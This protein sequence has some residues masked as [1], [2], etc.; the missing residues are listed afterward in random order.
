MSFHGCFVGF[1]VISK[2]GHDKG[3]HYVLTKVVDDKFVLVANGENRPLDAP[4]RKNIRHLFVTKS[5]TAA[6]N[7]LDIK[8]ALSDFYRKVKNEKVKKEGG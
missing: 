7:D 2:N 5:R 6:T 8:K 3:K 1:I 4:K